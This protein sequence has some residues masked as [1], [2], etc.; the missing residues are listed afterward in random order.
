MQYFEKHYH[1]TNGY[2]KVLNYDTVDIG[3]PVVYPDSIPPSPSRPSTNPEPTNPTPTIDRRMNIATT[4]NP[5]EPKCEKSDSIVR[6][7][8]VCKG[9]LLFEEL[10]ED[11]SLRQWQRE[12]KMPLD[13][14]VRFY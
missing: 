10:F 2:F 7:K 3:E 1:Q 4:K 11:S 9:E 14:E 6:G 13:S 5:L 8:E 12:I